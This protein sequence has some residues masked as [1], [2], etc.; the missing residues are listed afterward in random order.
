LA[1][2]DARL[3]QAGGAT[4]E[5]VVFAPDKHSLFVEDPDGNVLEFADWTRSW[6]DL[7]V[8]R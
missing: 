5:Y 3:R 6:E 7:P 8:E 4:V 1:A 2:L